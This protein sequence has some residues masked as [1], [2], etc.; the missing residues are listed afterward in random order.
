MAPKFPRNESTNPTEY[1][2]ERPE[3][4]PHDGESKKAKTTELKQKET[5]AMK[6][7]IN[8]KPW[9]GAVSLWA[10]AALMSYFGLAQLAQAVGEC[11]EIAS[12]LDLPVGTGTGVNDGRINVM[13]GT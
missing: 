5:T 4:T 3:I 1:L 2:S 12:G 8:K 11:T 9:P 13:L 10:I 6:P 7:N